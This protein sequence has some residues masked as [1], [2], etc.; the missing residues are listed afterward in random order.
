[1]KVSNLPSVHHPIKFPKFVSKMFVRIGLSFHTVS[2]ILPPIKFLFMDP[3]FGCFWP[4]FAPKVIKIL[5]NPWD[6][7]K[8]MTLVHQSNYRSAVMLMIAGKGSS[9]SLR[10]S[11]WV[12]QGFE[13]LLGLLSLPVDLITIDNLSSHRHRKGQFRWIRHREEKR[14]YTSLDHR[15]VRLSLAPCF[16]VSLLFWH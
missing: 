5:Q 14:L 6:D 1:M 2:H 4:R 15:C 3:N 13:L 7:T 12:L 11:S 9:D 16:C 10:S 8:N